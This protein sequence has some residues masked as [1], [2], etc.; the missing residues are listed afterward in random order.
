MHDRP[1][2]HGARPGTADAVPHH[3]EN[4]APMLSI[5]ASVFGLLLFFLLLV[6]LL[7]ESALRDRLDKSAGEGTYRLNWGG[8]GTGFVV[9]S[10]PDSLRI[11]ETGEGIGRGKICKQDGAFPRYANRVYQRRN[12]QLIFVLLEGSVTVMAEARNCLMTL[13]PQRPVHIS[14]IMADQELLKSVLLDD[15]PSYIEEQIQQP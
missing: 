12:N 6:N 15:I 8:G 4:N 2:S 3:E 9:I 5:F 10:F 1:F 7:S 11:V 13:M 14:W